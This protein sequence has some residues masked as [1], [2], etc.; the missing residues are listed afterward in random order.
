[1]FWG[2]LFGMVM[3]GIIIIAFLYFLF[4]LVMHREGLQAPAQASAAEILD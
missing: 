2:M 1:M 4:Q 3:G